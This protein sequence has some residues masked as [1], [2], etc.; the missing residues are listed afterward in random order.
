M[1][2]QIHLDQGLKQWTRYLFVS[3]YST[4]SSPEWSVIFLNEGPWCKPSCPQAP[5]LL[6]SDCGSALTSCP[7]CPL[8]LF[9]L[10]A[11]LKTLALHS[12]SG[13]CTCWDIW[14][15][16]IPKISQGSIQMLTFQKGFLIFSHIRIAP[17]PV[18][19][20]MLLAF[21]Y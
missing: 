12:A 6:E 15:E 9:S 8:D 16:L 20:L 21:S 4:R 11:V 2:V 3:S 7:H 10:S 1:F 13:L 5:S 17:Y 14:S 18:D 19:P